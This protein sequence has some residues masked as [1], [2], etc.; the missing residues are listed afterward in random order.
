MT[1][2]GTAND[3]ERRI[4]R[5]EARLENAIEDISNLTERLNNHAERLTAQER[6][7]TQL[8]VLWGVL[9]ALGT[10]FAETIKK[11]LGFE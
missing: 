5:G 2:G 3:H 4:S 10:L 11:K 1:D 9:V 6:F 8:L 7:K